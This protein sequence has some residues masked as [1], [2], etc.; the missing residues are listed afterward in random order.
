MESD[1][2]IFKG[3]KLSDL[4][5]EIY[6]NSRETKSQVKGL[7][8]ELK[9][10]IENIGDATLLV[11]M[12]KEYMEI[13]VKNDEHLI[14]LATVIQR[15]EAIQAKSS[16]GEMFDFSELQDLLE[17]SEDIK[18]EIQITQEEFDNDQQEEK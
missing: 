14:K 12:I 18:D 4:F 8:G 15:L 9:P 13:G 3:K 5:E 6:N 17:E 7:I 11:P 1:K 16:D 10:L 2:E